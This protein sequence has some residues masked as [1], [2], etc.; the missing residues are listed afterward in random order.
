M[1]D[2]FPLRLVAWLGLLCA[3]LATSTAAAAL[4]L[5]V[6]PAQSRVSDGATSQ[7]LSG[8]VEI[9]LGSDAGV[10]TT[11]FELT[12][13]VLLA[14]GLSV[15]LDPAAP[16]PAAGVVNAAG[17]FLI[18]TLFVAFDVGPARL[19]LGLPDVTGG[20]QFGGA[21]LT[22]LAATVEVDPG[23]GGP[24]RLFTLVALPEPQLGLLLMAA[25]WVLMRW[26]SLATSGREGSS[27]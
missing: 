19:A 4:T 9:V 23:D 27:R 15:G 24:V 5:T 16:N 20:V 13:L 11:T 26:R 22:E 17:A 18:P 2:R 1:S 25:P 3:C 8:T 14:P 10:S 12:S 21:G 7:P 6:D